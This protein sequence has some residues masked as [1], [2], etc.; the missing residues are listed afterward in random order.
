MGS[1][2]PRGGNVTPPKVVGLG[3]PISVWIYFEVSEIP[4]LDDAIRDELARHAARPDGW[5]DHIAELRRMLADVEQA[6]A[7]RCAGRFDVVWP[8]MLAHRV[9]HGAVSHAQR[10]ADTAVTGQPDEQA[11]TAV[12]EALAAAHQSRHDFNAVDNGGRDA[13]WL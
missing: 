10:R 9:V 8:T 12:R 11:V 6:R 5:N 3:A 13:V 2:H 4:A 1:N 7:T